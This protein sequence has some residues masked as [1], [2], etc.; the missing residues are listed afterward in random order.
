MSTT[1]TSHMGQVDGYYTDSSVNL[2][3]GSTTLS[4]TFITK[5]IPLHRAR[6]VD[7]NIYA[8]TTGSPDYTFKMQ[9]S[10]DETTD[11]KENIPSANLINWADLPSGGNRTVSVQVN[12]ATPKLL[13]DPDCTSKWVRLVGTK[14]SGSITPTIRIHVKAR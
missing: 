5:P 8:P 1:S 12:S 14:S 6:S 2:L 3:D 4:A 9:V 10:N 13:S 7:F 11:H